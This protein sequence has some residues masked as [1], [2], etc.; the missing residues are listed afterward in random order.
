MPQQISV[1]A[2]GVNVTGQA[3]A[4]VTARRFT[5]ISGNRTAKGNLAVATAAAG[6]RAFGVA[7]NDAAIGDLVDIVRGG[8]VRVDAGG[9][10]TAGAE[11]EVGATGKAIT[12]ASGIAVGYV[13]T[14]AANNGVAEVH[15]HV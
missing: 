2:P 14:G 3:T 10:I 7:R 12:K 9:A 6:A 11:V 13:V 8:V 15:L 1:Y 5:A 4:A